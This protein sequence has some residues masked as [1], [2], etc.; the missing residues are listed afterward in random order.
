MGR[1]R[2]LLIALPYR[3]RAPF[4]AFHARKERFAVLV[5]HRRA[6][7]TV[8]CINDLVRAAVTCR[9]PQPRFAYLA[10]FYAQAKDV[11]F[12]YLRHFTGPIPG[13]AANVAELRVDLPNGARVRLYG[14]ENAERL[15]GLYFD[16]IVI[17][18]PADMDP[19]VW[20]EIIRPALADR[21]GWAVFIG[22]PKGRNAFCELWEAALKDPAWFTL[23]LKASETGILPAAEL[24]AARL[25]MSEDQYAQE[26]ECSFDAAVQGSYY[27]A[28]IAGLEK[29]KR[30]ARVPYEPGALVHT[31]WDLGIGDSTAI[32][33][34]QAVG[35]EVRLIDYEEASGV[36]LD[37]YVRLLK[38]KPYIY[39]DHILPHDA[40]ISEL[41][42]GRTRVETLRN[43]GINPRVLPR[44]SVE[45]GINAA[46]LLLARSWFD[47]ERCARGIEALRQ[48]RREFDEKLK[49]FRARPLHDWTSHA[50]DAF[51]Y[52]AVGLR[53]EPRGR[54][55]GSERISAGSGGWMG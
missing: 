11:A 5:C 40:G 41:G 3:P 21:A 52:L 45:D 12:D 51:R 23:M 4:E 16:G 24:E 13:A 36:G 18:E 6:G 29:E 38:S 55:A 28:L 9:K 34:A 50:A 25:A 30:L 32:W 14:A 42:T 48:Y 8:A 22:T 33:F 20:P 10:P 35:L 1:N 44:G 47:A 37:H 15:R 7:K 19:R 53:A 17:D 49:A 2:D 26:F 43:L 31:A 46:R 54:K 39:G 27:G